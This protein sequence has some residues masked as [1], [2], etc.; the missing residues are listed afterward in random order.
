MLQASHAKAFSLITFFICQAFGSH[1]RLFKSKTRTILPF[2]LPEIKLTRFKL[3]GWKGWWIMGGKKGSE[4]QLLWPLRQ[5]SWRLE[6]KKLV[7]QL[8]ESNRHFPRKSF[9]PRRRSKLKSFSIL[10]SSSNQRAE[11]FP[12]R[13]YPFGQEARQS[14]VIMLNKFN[15]RN[16]EAE[17]IRV[18]FVFPRWLRQNNFGF[19]EEK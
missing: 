15:Y 10:S 7:K 5:S 3:R 14:C 11:N 16:I 12:L 4:A 17:S 1:F 8:K 9:F 19:G 18:R 13:C 6:E 2:H